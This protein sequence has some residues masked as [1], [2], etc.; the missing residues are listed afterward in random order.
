MQENEHQLTSVVYALEEDIVLGRLRPHQELVEDVLMQR[1]DIKRH[2][3][4]AA[5]VDLTAKGLVVKQRN[6]S[7]RV[8]DYTPQ[9]VDWIYD[10][11][12]TLSRHAVETMPLPAHPQ[13]LQQIKATHAEH[14]LAVA[15][16]RLS[17]V[18]HHNDR[19]H[20]LIFSACGN[21]YLLADLE[22]YNRLSDPIRSTG[23]ASDQWLPRAIEDH[24][25]MIAAMESGDRK[26]LAR[27]VVAH[28]LPVRDTWL[29]ARQLLA[30]VGA[31]VVAQP[32]GA[33]S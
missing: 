2:L 19:F 7:A 17:D 13:L 21:P 1:F 33:V 15:Q 16:R 31:G 28:M 5:I 25:A 30:P 20:D 12:I 24:A 22:R 11:R 6:K 14:Q 3:A 29:A 26:Q 23:I 9:E 4:R 27:V 18:R 10:V 8:K 32:L